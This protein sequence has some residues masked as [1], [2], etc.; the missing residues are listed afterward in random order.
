MTAP[1]G[2]GPARGADRR[3]P[4]SAPARL[5]ATAA[6]GLVPWLVVRS[7]GT[8]SLVGSFGLV[9]PAPWH[10]T[11]VWTYLLELTAGLPP[12]LV[13]WPVAA[14][15]WL[16]ALASAAGGALLD[17][18]DRR[19]TGGLLVLV[20]LSLLAVA[21]TVGRSRGA[22]ALPVGTAAVWLVA[23]WAHG[24]ALRHAVRA[25]PTGPPR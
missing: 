3:R 16:A 17:R 21:G 1:D 18:E 9:G 7:A 8:W 23:W 22:V 20:G 15:L 5:V 2:V 11:P 6:V 24:D 14:V 4:P 25:G 12:G 10:V 13:A 19:L